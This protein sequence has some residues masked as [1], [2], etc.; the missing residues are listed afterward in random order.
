MNLLLK[1]AIYLIEHFEA[2]QLIAYFEFVTVLQES[3]SDRLAIQNRAVGRVEIGQAIA[4]HSRLC[5]GLRADASVHAGRARVVDADVSVQSAP[6]G[7]FR[8]FQWNLYRK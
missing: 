3:L 4:N 5:I 7:H 1:L 2:D 6:Q 8:A